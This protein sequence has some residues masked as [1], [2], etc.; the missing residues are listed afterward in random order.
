MNHVNAS[1]LGELS[2]TIPLFSVLQPL[3]PPHKTLSRFYEPSK[4]GEGPVL[5]LMVEGVF[6]VDLKLPRGLPALLAKHKKGE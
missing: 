6:N 3:Q 1:G 5:S 2:R 4:N